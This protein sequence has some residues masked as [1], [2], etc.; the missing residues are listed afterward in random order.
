MIDVAQEE[1]LLDRIRDL[2]GIVS[3]KT[4]LINK[5]VEYMRRR[6]DS[7][8]KLAAELARYKKALW[9]ANGMLMMRNAEPVKLEYPQS[10][11]RDG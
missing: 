9:T 1:G 8:V 5:L 11:E 6:N 7:S 10:E 4:A 3:R 2:E